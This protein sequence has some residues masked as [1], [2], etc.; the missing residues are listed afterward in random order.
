M[1][2]RCVSGAVPYR[3]RP[4]GNCPWRKDVEPG[5]FP[6]SRYE[7]L[8]VTSEQREGHEPGIGAPL[9]ACHKTPEGREIACAGWLAAVG[10][11]HIGVR[12]AVA[13]R[14]LPPEVLHPGDDWPE[15]FDTYDE[16]ATRQAG[17]ER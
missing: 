10:H 14:R 2:A 13:Q 12:L 1:T 5:E 16:M 7:E 3:R 8:R 4:C 6:A 11:R 15:L 9:F 17:D